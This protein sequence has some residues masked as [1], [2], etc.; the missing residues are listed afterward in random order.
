MSSFGG[1]GNV[2]QLKQQISN[3][4]G[5]I[6]VMDGS[7]NSERILQIQNNL[8][9]LNFEYIF[10]EG[11]DMQANDNGVI[12]LFHDET[13]ID[14]VVTTAG[15][16]DALNDCYRL[17]DNGESDLVKSATLSASSEFSVDNS[18]EKI[19]DDDTSVCW[20]SGDGDQQTIQFELTEPDVTSELVIT[21]ADGTEFE[22]APNTFVL[23]GSVSGVFAGEE[24]ELLSVAGYPWLQGERASWAISNAGA[25]QYYQLVMTGK[26]DIFGRW[27][28]Y[29]IAELE[30]LKA[31]P[32]GFQDII[33]QSG[34]FNAGINPNRA[35]LYLWHEQ[36]DGVVLN[37]DLKAY[38]SR[39]S[40]VTWESVE[41]INVAGLSVGVLLSAL[42]V[43]L[44]GQT[45]GNS[46]VWK[47]ET[48]NLKEQR[49]RGVGVQ[50][51]VSS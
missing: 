34:A 26:Q 42:D 19:T 7:G 31:G 6:D 45:A 22:R 27:A 20:F 33:I 29:V 28:E 40:G 30:L 37:T 35:D 18:I 36:I 25:Y 11:L 23:Y 43:D 49:V 41:L 24:V 8:A 16:Y 9:K 5:Q 32:S 1:G 48:L 17:V 50:W 47:V 21:A 51:R 10:R 44:S 2:T 38:V 12:D 14:A 13:D 39:D 15:S 4:Q 3:I 46:V